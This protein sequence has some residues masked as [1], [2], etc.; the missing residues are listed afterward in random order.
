MVSAILVGAILCLNG[1]MLRRYWWLP[2]ILFALSGLFLVIWRIVPKTGN[3][4]TWPTLEMV[5]ENLTFFLQGLTFP[6]QPR[7]RC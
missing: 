5:F 2:I 1:R 6:V 3:R 4:V 7:P